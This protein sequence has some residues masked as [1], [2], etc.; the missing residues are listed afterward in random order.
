MLQI[1][2]GFGWRLTAFAALAGLAAGLIALLLLIGRPAPDALPPAAPPVVEEAAPGDGPDLPEP[3][4][5][6]H[7][8]PSTSPA[9]ASIPYSR[10]LAAWQIV[11]EAA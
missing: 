6:C 2:H 5:A 4:L 3:A 11:S 1:Q 7:R 8:L 10:K 9:N